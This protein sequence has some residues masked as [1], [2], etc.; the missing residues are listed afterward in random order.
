VRTYIIEQWDT[1]MANLK[2]KVGG[3]YENG[4]GA[5]QTIVRAPNA[6]CRWFE[7]ELGDYYHE[8]GAFVS[9]RGGRPELNLLVHAPDSPR[10]PKPAAYSDRGNC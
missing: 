3:K 1:D 2:L 8:D 7:S 9:I 6:K 10:P 4:F 5:V